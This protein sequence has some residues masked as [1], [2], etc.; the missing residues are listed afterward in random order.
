MTTADTARSDDSVRRDVESELA[1]VPGLDAAAIGVG[2]TE[3]VVTLSGQVPTLWLRHE[4]AAAALRIHGV[5]GLA[6]ELEVLFA[7]TAPSDTEIA[8]AIAHQLRWTASLPD[9]AV[10][11]EV[12]DGVVTLRGVVQH[13]S[14]RRA[15]ERQ[16]RA[17]RG[18]RWITD[19][20]A[21]SDRASAADTKERIAEAL[22]RNAIIDAGSIEVEADG[23]TVTLSG[24]VGSWDEKRQAERTAWSSP[25]VALVRNHLAVTP[26]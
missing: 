20:I 1:W 16:T 17:I 15:I 6:N 11:P 26:R 22:K 9:G 13:D 18:V 14:E 7:G 4:A 3:G 5:K 19:D 8:D 10:T 2:V 21:L 25:H 12:R 24:T 23:T